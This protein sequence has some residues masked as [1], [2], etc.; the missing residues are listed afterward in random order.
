MLTIR[1]KLLTVCFFLLIVPILV[2]GV[3]A[4][5][6]ASGETTDLIQK[7]LKNNV[8]MA[9]EMLNALDE[10][11]RQGSLPR[12]EA[13]ETL[14]TLLLGAKQ[15]DN[16]RPINKTIDLGENGYFYVMDDKGNLLAHPSNEGENIWD[17]QTSDGTYYIRDVTAAALAGGG[18]TYYDWPLPESDKEARKIVYAEINPNWGW[19][20]A[21]GSYV[22]DYNEGERAILWALGITLVCCVVGG[23]IALVLFSEHISRPAIRIT[24][25]AEQISQGDLTGEELNIRNRDEIGRLGAAFNR[26]AHNLRELAGNQLLSANALAS[27]STQ[28]SSVIGDTVRAAHQTSESL[29]E[30]AATNE[31]QSKGIEETAKAMEEMTI[32]IGRIANSAGMTFEASAS[33]LKRAEEGRELIGQSSDRMSTISGT[34]GEIGQVVG[35]LGDRS[36]QIADISLAIRE[37]SAQTNLLALNASIEAAR[38]GEHGQGFSVVAG[39]IRK[40][41]ERSDESAIQVTELIEAIVGDIEKA[42]A[43]M[44]RGERDVQL[45]I[46]SI[47]QTGEAFAH[48][49]E[50]TRSVADQAEEASAAA[51]QMSASA[52]EVAASL[53]QMERGSARS[54]ETAG[55]I[56]AANEEQLASMDEIASSA[57][58]LSQMSVNMKELAGRFKIS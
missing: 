39:E 34:V 30:L 15:A 3:V 11:V 1:K 50:A 21:A 29:A 2:L 52:Q 58:R 26:L 53:Q 49:Y 37:I 14:R 24:R 57:E 20:I 42:G 51:E 43:S 54:A 44:E 46:A 55:T 36:Q 27:S 35:R 9:S 32:G 18:F 47:R 6:V 19:V 5:R 10:S 4:Y 8:R 48:I 41:A 22:Q 12:E 7:G 23:L 25:L 28:L 38:A 40:L 16:T 45:G 56:S 31:T 17:K 33:T 13:E